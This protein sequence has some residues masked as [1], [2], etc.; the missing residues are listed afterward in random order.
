VINLKDVQVRLVGWQRVAVF[1]AG[2]K[3]LDYAVDLLIDAVE[4]GG[5]RNWIDVAVLVP[6]CFVVALV[7]W[8]IAFGDNGLAAP[9]R[10][11][12]A[13]R[14]AGRPNR[15]GREPGRGRT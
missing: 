10:T 5:V 7:C 6:F 14:A 12:G 13:E 8:R 3:V 15:D 2:M 4:H 11:A 1:F 9:A